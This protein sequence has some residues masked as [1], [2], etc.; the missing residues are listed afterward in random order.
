MKG[1][2][3]WTV[4]LD[5]GARSF[6]WTGRCKREEK[7]GRVNNRQDREETE[8]QREDRG[9]PVADTERLG[10]GTRRKEGRRAGGKGATRTLVGLERDSRLVARTST[11]HRSG[12]GGTG[13]QDSTSTGEREGLWGF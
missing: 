10:K 2:V 11:R 9:A 4:D 7:T 12:R 13:A 5:R 3:R 1:V 6:T 8:T